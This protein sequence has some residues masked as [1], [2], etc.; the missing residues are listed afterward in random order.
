MPGSA[1]AAVGAEILLALLETA[2]VEDKAAALEGALERAAL[3]STSRRRRRADAGVH[4]HSFDESTRPL[5]WSNNCDPMMESKS[6]DSLASSYSWIPAQAD[7]SSSWT[8]AFRKRLR[9]D[10]VLL[11]WSSAVGDA[12]PRSLSLSILED[13]HGE[14]VALCGVHVLSSRTSVSIGCTDDSG[15]ITI[16]G[17]P[18][19]VIAEGVKLIFPAGTPLVSAISCDFCGM[20]TVRPSKAAATLRGCAATG[21][22][23]GGAGGFSDAI[24]DDMTFLVQNGV[25]PGAHRKEKCTLVRSIVHVSPEP[26][27]RKPCALTPA[28][29]RLA[30]EQTAAPSTRVLGSIIAWATAERSPLAL[31]AA[32]VAL[33]RL[34]AQ[35]TPSLG[36][37]PVEALSDLA[38]AIDESASACI[39]SMQRQL[40]DPFVS[41]CDRI[42]LISEDASAGVTGETV[43]VDSR[44]NG[45][46]SVSV[47]LSRATLG[48]YG[49]VEAAS[50][51]T[52]LS[53]LS[54]RRSIA[55][56]WTRAGSTSVSEAVM[57]LYGA[58]VEGKPDPTSM[59]LRMAGAEISA[60]LV[61][62]LTIEGPPN[63][64]PPRGETSSRKDSR[65]LRPAYSHFSFRAIVE[66]T[67]PIRATPVRII[68]YSEGI[69][70][71]D[72]LWRS[73]P[74]CL[75]GDQV[76]A[77]VNIAMLKGMVL[78]IE[79]VKHFDRGLEEAAV[80]SSSAA[81]TSVYP[82]IVFQDAFLER[83]FAGPWLA[84]L[85]LSYGACGDP[86]ITKPIAEK[87][88][89]CP[90]GT[91]PPDAAAVVPA[92]LAASFILS[93]LAWLA[94]LS[95]QAMR[96][97]V[98]S[99]TQLA[100]S[101]LGASAASL[102][103]IN[104]PE[105]ARRLCAHSQSV[106]SATGSAAG[107]LGRRGAPKGA[108]APVNDTTAFVAHVRDADPTYKL[109]LFAFPATRRSA[110]A[111]AAL[112]S[113]ALEAASSEGKAAQSAM[114]PTVTGAGPTSL[115]S[116]AAADSSVTAPSATGDESMIK[117]RR[118]NDDA[119][120]ADTEA[121]AHPCADALRSSLL[122]ARALFSRASA[123]GVGARSMTGRGCRDCAAAVSCAGSPPTL[124]SRI[125]CDFLDSEMIS[126]PSLPCCFS[127]LRESLTS[128]VGA[129]ATPAVHTLRRLAAVSLDEAFSLTVQNAGARRKALLEALSAGA[130]LI[131]YLPL[132]AS[133]PTLSPA[134][135]NGS[136][137]KRTP[138]RSAKHARYKAA[139]AS[140]ES[141]EG[142]TPGFGSTSEKSPSPAECEMTSP[143]ERGESSHEASTSAAYTANLARFAVLVQLE[144]ARA[145]LEAD[146]RDAAASQSQAIFVRIVMAPSRSAAAVRFV[147]SGV[148]RALADAGLGNW[149]LPRGARSLPLEMERFCGA[150]GFPQ[151]RAAAGAAAAPTAS[152][153]L[154]LAVGDVFD[155]PPAP[156]H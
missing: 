127:A 65:D 32:A 94:E 38:A 37:V 155:H 123:I 9:V 81:S 70:G 146:A 58:V 131:F 67:S 145:G 151:N 99:I 149:V 136:P 114:A 111:L 148:A 73:P 28:L 83:T 30:L 76:R 91:L 156:A 13:A 51:D 11:E 12:A 121:R 14:R 109:P 34:P 71:G 45:C 105:A 140:P 139:V 80:V 10:A 134:R 90:P 120:M 39:G 27:G 35:G 86:A 108:K 132:F 92:N 122:L 150:Q 118:R 154:C 119:A 113:V 152:A 128:V 60:A 8:V 43:R 5:V 102:A 72:E 104:T 115:P 26:T 79:S 112:V 44:Y 3:A 54:P 82:L 125:S 116:F 93:R 144:A 142:S 48:I 89:L 141:V 129:D 77:R 18:F 130:T 23:M 33:L 59:T 96:V 69:W 19:E 55:R 117:L 2:S 57:A 103:L 46:V 87:D 78:V 97:G 29:I 66:D 1:I 138:T 25:L 50:S 153:R 6:S 84:P 53:P 74:L 21:A 42:A 4:G 31:A 107:L 95:S 64:P 135:V 85:V 88:Y 68:I 41:L 56:L 47:T 24:T 143:S 62:P 147:E 52:A 40:K 75:P 17:A 63:A 7:D 15:S 133:Q 49:A 124:G 22:G 20:S 98:D 36:G 126:A 101:E 16:D 61:I 106:A 137:L 110:D 100:V